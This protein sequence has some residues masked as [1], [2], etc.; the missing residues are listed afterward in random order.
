MK[1]AIIFALLLSFVLLGLTACG[2][3]EA[4]GSNGT[5]GNNKGEYT[6]SAPVEYDPEKVFS[7]GFRDLESFVKFKEMTKKSED[8][9]IQYYE[10]EH[11]EE[12]TGKEDMHYVIGIVGNIPVPDLGPEFTFSGMT[13]DNKSGYVIIFYEK[14][15]ERIYIHSFVDLSV[16]VSAD[17]EK[18]TEITVNSKPVELFW[19]F[20]N[21]THYVFS[22]VTKGE[23]Y[24]MEILLPRMTADEIKEYFPE[25]IEILTIDQMIMKN[26]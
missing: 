19:N 16:P 23:G 25:N 15:G 18:F 26:W 12:Y 8:E 10:E 14:D 7:M 24:L 11:F 3:D 1:K 21:S 2:D 13:L 5:A 4:V 22:G 9:I 6:L 20:S 17:G